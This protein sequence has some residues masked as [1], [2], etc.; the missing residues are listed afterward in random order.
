MEER[1]KRTG[2]KNKPTHER[3]LCWSK[4]NDSHFVA[5]FTGIVDEVDPIKTTSLYPMSWGGYE[6]G[7]YFELSKPRF[8]LFSVLSSRKGVHTVLTHCRIL[9]R[10]VFCLWNYGLISRHTCTD[11][12]IQGEKEPKPFHFS[13]YNKR[14]II[15]QKQWV[16]TGSFHFTTNNI[17]LFWISSL[18]WNMK[19]NLGSDVW[20]H[21]ISPQTFFILVLLCYG[22]LSKLE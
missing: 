4:A 10:S 21:Y 11:A 15:D 20:E 7:F 12:A 3:P 18:L 14:D 16:L 5:I 9:S 17:Y 22:M 13:Y 2:T 8:E 1:G 19:S 6:G